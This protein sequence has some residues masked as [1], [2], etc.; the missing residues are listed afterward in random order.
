[1]ISK[2]NIY[3]APQSLIVEMQVEG[4]VLKDSQTENFEEETPWVN[5]NGWN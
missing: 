3:E 4:A 1:M 2:S 5:G